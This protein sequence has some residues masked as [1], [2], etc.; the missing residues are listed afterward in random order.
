VQCDTP[1]KDWITPDMDDA[2]RVLKVYNEAGYINCRI[3]HRFKNK[4]IN[5]DTNGTSRDSSSTSGPV[6][7]TG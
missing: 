5:D 1:P 3:V 4:E 6:L 7:E 2:K